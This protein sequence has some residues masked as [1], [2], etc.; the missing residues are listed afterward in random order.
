MRRI[1][2]I[3]SMSLIALGAVAAPAA[4]ASTSSS[5]VRVLQPVLASEVGPF[6]F[7][8]C[9]AGSA[10]FW[11]SDNGG[12]SMWRAP[13]CGFFVL[14][15][16]YNNNIESVRNRGGGSAILWNNNNGT[17]RIREIYN[18]SLNV[19]LTEAQDNKTS[20]ITILC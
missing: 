6:A 5:P 2:A 8:D 19:E 17:S 1:T 16:S 14:G 4:Y 13:S 20:S 12:G 15:S 9:P 10:C 7:S 3:I 18:N 11:T